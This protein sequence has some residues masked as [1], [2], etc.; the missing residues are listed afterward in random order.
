MLCARFNQLIK[1][2]SDG[3]GL[4]PTELDALIWIFSFD[5]GL[6]PVRALRC[7]SLKVPNLG[8]EKRF[9]SLIASETVSK[10]ISS[11]ARIS[12]LVSLI[13]RSEER[14]VG[15]ECRSRWAPYH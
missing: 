13:S 14:R 5:C 1:S 8:H 2:C 3:D 4:K 6:R 7:L 11:S 15:K 9:S 12:F 10:T